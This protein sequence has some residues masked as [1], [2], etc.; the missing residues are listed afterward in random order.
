[1]DPLTTD[2]VTVPYVPDALKPV[3]TTSPVVKVSLVGVISMVAATTAIEYACV[4]D[5][6]G[7]VESV[8]LIVNDA[9]PVP[10]QVPEINPAPLRL[11]PLGKDP[12]ARA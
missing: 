11:K 10:V 5:R 1:M 9:V 3:S 2:Q 7:L 6:F 8:D 4:I 12:D